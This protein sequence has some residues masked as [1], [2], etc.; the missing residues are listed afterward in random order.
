[1]RIRCLILSW[2]CLGIISGVLNADQLPFLSKVREQTHV[3]PN[4][5]V[6]QVQLASGQTIEISA[7]I[8]EPSSL[9]ANARLR[10]SWKLLTANDPTQVPRGPSP[11]ETSARKMDEFDIY[12]EPSAD[13]SKILHALDPSVYVIYR[14]PVT[15]LY[16]LR[17]TPEEKA[18]D[19]FSTERWREPGVAPQ[20]NPAPQ[21]VVWPENAVARVTS[22]LKPIDLSGESDA[23]LFVETEPNDTPEQA[24]PISLQSTL[25]N[26]TV[27]VMGTSDDIEYFDNGK[28]GASG[29]DWYRLEY[30]GTEPRLLT[31]CLSIPDQ[32]VAARI[33]VYTTEEKSLISGKLLP[34]KEYDEGKN[35]NER[36]HQQEEQHRIA[37]NRTM[38]PGGI[39][40]LR[41]EANAPGYDLELRVVSPA[42]FNDPRQAIR[43]GL[44]DHIGQVDAWLTNRPRGA[45]VER[46][47]RD[48]G[49]LLGTN[50]MS[51]HTQS[52]VWGPAVPF[53]Q[54]YRPQNVQNWRHLVNT[55]YQS[56]RPTNKLVDAAN[57]TSLQPLDLGDGPAGTRVAGHSVVAF[58]RF[59]SPRKLQSQQA[60]RAANFVLQS[61]DPTG[62][63]AA[64]PGANVGKGVVYNYAGEIVAAA[65]RKTGE[66]RYFHA[67][68]DKAQRMLGDID[69]AMKTAAIKYCDDLGH[70]VEFFSR[71][72]PKEYAL[73]AAQVAEQEQ[74]DAAAKAEV[75]QKAKDFETR[76]RAQV[77]EDL[78]RLRAI[79][80]EDGSWGFD[81]GQRQGD[82][83]MVSADTPPDPSPTA[84]ALIAFEA[85][86]IGLNDPTVERGIKALLK[87][88][89]P[90][91]YWNGKSITGFVSTSY[92]LHALSRYFPTDPP[93]YSKEQFQQREGESL[94]AAIR[95]V[96]DLS[97]TEDVRFVSELIESAR[98]ANPLVRYWAMIGLGTMRSDEAVPSLVKS[99]PDHARIVRE[100]AHWG[101]RQQLIDDRGWERVL[102]VAQQ[103]DDYER[104]A[105]M[106]ALIMKVDG[107]MPKTVVGYDRLATVLTFALN[108]DPHPG[109]RAWATRA[110]W[111]W[112]IWN[113]PMRAALNAAWLDLLEREEPELLVENAIR[114]QTHALFIANGH[115]ANGSSQHQYKELETLFAHIH[116]RLKQSQE[117]NSPLAERLSARLLAVA[118][119]YYKQRGGDG[120][121]G[122]MGYVTK[123]SSE[124]FSNAVLAQLASA[125]AITEN[126]RRHLLTRLAL[127]G[128]ANV[129]NET[130][131]AK[132]VDYSLHGPEDLRKI[133]ADSISDPRLVNLIAV[134]EQLEPMYAQL[135]RG[136]SDPPRRGNLSEP[137]LK[138]YGG[139]S[140]DLPT[141]EEQRHEILQYLVPQVTAWKAKTVLEELTNTAEQS[142]ATRDT[143]AAWY[144]ASGLGAAIERN[145]DLHFE[146]LAEAF[147]LK[148]ENPAEARFWIRSVPWILTFE[149]ELPEVKVDPKA[150]PPI[151][152]YEELRSRALRLFLTQL[153]EN[154]LA[155]NR[156]VAV[157]LANKTAL[158]KNPE[159]LTSLA[160]LEKFEKDASVLEGAKKVLSQER[161]A[162]AKQLTAAISQETNH[163]FTNDDSGVVE[164]PEDFIQDLTY[165]RDYVVPEMTK[166]LR[167]DERSCMI[168]HGEPG[169]VPSMEL[170]P[171]D[172]V[173]F[174]AT[175]KLLENY[176]I[177]QTR[178]T[179]DDLDNSKLLRKPLNVQSGK[180]DGHQGGRR[181][182]PM[183]AGYLI[184]KKW[185]ENQVVI[186]NRYGRPVLP[187]KG[188]E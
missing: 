28:V 139:V 175:D 165:F 77:A 157:E 56:M 53:A 81:P 167:G 94:V 160:S 33:R 136:A 149:R 130:L 127:E 154:A 148:F 4:D 90:T 10:I 11:D 1:M 153:D 177:L 144:L 101:L 176:R 162:F 82:S 69:G 88:Q 3:I 13:W 60:I 188:P 146:Q 27:N 150:L 109:V 58:E 62:I 43:H 85:A 183:D 44:Y 102:S 105:A 110:A 103:G 179:I 172:Q 72:F 23:H 47:I 5:G 159:I 163:G 133:A 9:T 49:N 40:L 19:L 97:A 48:S 174:L 152:P 168:C 98:H 140:W 125:E 83:W 181:Y 26:Y 59:C 114:Y 108:Q 37:I 7:A 107:V 73:T 156:K 29:D 142:Q 51:C 34:L 16:E 87:Q 131:Q 89:H 96:R 80:L 99:L 104:E 92:A 31:A 155:E 65:W 112:W 12:A 116:Q 6:E 61:S 18:I 78:A 170:N 122:Q 91:G 35:P 68:E 25:D 30:P 21:S 169:R 84:L 95:R 66:T 86:G 126:N 41:V 180:E 171:P 46:R 93:T 138:M 8:L 36:A 20:S 2:W 45:S 137:I 14:A 118:A 166:V 173:G 132:L 115:I 129:G 147:P 111:Q 17:I 54:G 141:S 178:I 50:C 161:G 39:Y 67:M 63:N 158:R 74:L 145:P 121:A 52:G 186:Q 135:L 124:L 113:P 15:G 75:V 38:K 22:T 79:Q 187:Q 119:T 57:N 106:R 185:A 117:S 120:G 55:C 71:Y 123:G 100:A 64:G 42:P 134:P 128:A 182:Q 184:L 151:D 76:V 24:Q 70:R 32:Q 164:I 143:D